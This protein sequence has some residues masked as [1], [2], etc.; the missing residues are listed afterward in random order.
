[1]ELPDYLPERIREVVEV[2]RLQWYMRSTASTFP[3]HK[4]HLPSFS[5]LLTQ[6]GQRHQCPHGCIACVFGLVRQ[7]Q[8]RSASELRRSPPPAPSASCAFGRLVQQTE[9]RRCVSA[10]SLV[11]LAE[12]RRNRQK[13]ALCIVTHGPA[14]GAL[15]SLSPALTKG[16]IPVALKN[17]RSYSF[18][19]AD[20]L[21]SGER[22]LR[23]F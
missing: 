14:A 9:K 23:K 22:L 10:W 18:S 17:A 3:R 19:G 6:V 8:H 5:T 15:L 13:S 11:H 21:T 1:M 4:G 2:D 12:K 7:M 20:F 16:N